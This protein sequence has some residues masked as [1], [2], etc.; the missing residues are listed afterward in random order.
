MLDS[1]EIRNFRNLKELRITSL[2]RVNL[3]IGKNNTGKSTI[4]EALAIYASKGEFKTIFELL[5]ERGEYVSVEAIRQSE[6]GKNITDYNMQALSTLFTDRVIS[7]DKKYG[8]SISQIDPSIH[9]EE[10]SEHYVM[11]LRFVPFRT[12][13]VDDGQGGRIRRRNFMLQDDALQEAQ[14]DNLDTGFMRMGGGFFSTTSL[15]KILNDNVAY[16]DN[17]R[18]DNF[19]FIKTNTIDR[20][21][22]SKLFDSIALTDKE[23]YVVDALKI[24]E[25]TTERIA[26]VGNTSQERVAVIKLANNPRILP[27]RSMGDGMNR[28]LTIILA[29]V[30]ADNGFLLID[31]F[32]NGLHY[33]TQE[34]LWKV[35]FSLAK[36]LNIQVFATTHSEDCIRGFEAVLNSSGQGD[37]KLIR[38][39]NE[40]GMIKEVEFNAEELK[41]AT[42]RNIEIR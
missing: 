5:E 33:T 14:H 35:I 15:D 19:Q 25:P 23:Q 3:F 26:F 29:M 10:N 6:A 27:L 4:L 30:N 13:V 21:I 7:F 38:L 31:E 34:Q 39:H 36:Q 1:L 32:E 20:N 42:N 17:G 41:I 40:N 18:K 9:Q 24:I 2:G 22:N 12:E 16:T 11:M 28:I 37:G 8:I